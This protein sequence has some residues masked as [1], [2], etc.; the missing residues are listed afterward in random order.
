MLN[1][2]TELKYHLWFQIKLRGVEKLV[3]LVLKTN[4]DL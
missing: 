4:F 1:E 3:N 2:M